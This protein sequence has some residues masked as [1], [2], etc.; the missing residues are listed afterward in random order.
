MG[1]ATVAFALVRLIPGDPAI[2]L[3]GDR[4]DPA[5]LE[6]YRDLL[7]LTGPT[8]EQLVRYLLG[9][10]QGD[11]GTS[12]IT[13]RPVIQIVMTSMPVTLA[14][15]GLAFVLSTVVAVPVALVTA[16]HPRETVRHI[17]RFVAAVLI[18][19]PVFFT[20]V[21][22]IL[23]FAAWLGWAPAGGLEPG[24]FGSLRS[25]WLPAL[26]LSILLTPLLARVLQTSVRRT[27]SEEFVETAVARGIPRRRLMTGY[28]LRPSVAPTIALLGYLV[29]TQLGAAVI[30][31]FVFNIPGIGTALVTAVSTRDYPAVQG[32]VFVFGL[33][34]V[35]VNAL[36]T[37]ISSWLDPRMA[38]TS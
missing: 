15:L 10:V 26:V 11:L 30:V 27:A 2:L 9:M 16:L 23:V 36:A 21:I 33:V 17:F 28:I 13:G 12:I 19:S 7:G 35:V 18:A 6:R 31:E 5:Q 4:A 8:H 25:L 34:V 20:G 3:L 29:G 24:I 14:L 22:G 1:V 37:S 32:I 38:E